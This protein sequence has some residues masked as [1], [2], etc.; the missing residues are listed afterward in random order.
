MEFITQTYQKTDTNSKSI[1]AIEK[2]IAQIAEQIGKR[3]EGK[4]PSNTTINPSHNQRPGKEHQ[5]NQVITLRN[6]K[7]VDNKVSPLPLDNDSDV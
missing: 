2:Q 3:E 7:K 5:V 1:A 6:G 4:F